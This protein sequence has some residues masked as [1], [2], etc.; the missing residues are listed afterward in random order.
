MNIRSLIAPI[1]VF[2][3]AGSLALAGCTA[4]PAN[5]EKSG[6]AGQHGSE[7]AATFV[8]CLTAAGVGAKITDSG[9]VAVRSDAQPSEGGVVSSE[10]GLIGMEG[11]DEGN[12]W[13]IPVD[14]NYFAGDA[15]T[16]DA[17]AGCEKEY[18]DFSQPQVDPADDPAIRVNM[19]QQEEAALAFAQCARA[20]GYSRFEDPDFSKANA[21][22]IPADLT[23]EEFRAILEECWDREGAVFNLGQ[24][25]DA[26]FEAWAVLEEFLNE[27]AS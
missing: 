21:L 13:V 11:D 6:S 22:Q 12:S 15:T 25:L 20:T 14:S 9:Q 10:D 16:Q 26:P 24:P 8:A 2:V 27:P 19:L 18:P 1:A 4:A 7:D 3:V 23:E 17:Y 5:P